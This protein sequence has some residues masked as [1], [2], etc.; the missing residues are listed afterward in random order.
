[1]QQCE[2]S[3]SKPKRKR[4]R[5]IIKHDSARRPDSNQE[6]FRAFACVLE[7]Y[8]SAKSAQPFGS[9]LALLDSTLRST[10]RRW[11]PDSAHTVIDFENA[12]KK[13]LDNAPLLQE[14]F[15]IWFL[16]SNLEDHS[17]LSPSD[18]QLQGRIVQKCA[19][20]FL[21]RGMYPIYKWFRP[22]QKHAKGSQ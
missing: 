4:L 10:S 9:S 2:V 18:R 14:K 16:D 21:R 7:V 5:S 22:T 3:S 20:E 15:T 13:A 12:V 17:R 19:N 1:M 8:L 6:L 11:T